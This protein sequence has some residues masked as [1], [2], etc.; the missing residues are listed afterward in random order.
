MARLLGA[1]YVEGEQAAEARVAH[2]GD[3]RMALQ[4]PGEL[5]RR[6]GLPAHPELERL[7]PAQE[8]GA[9]IR[10][11]HDAEPRPQLV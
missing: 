2:L 11:R 1:R 7:Q 8:Q 9:G 4:A 6:L 10:R 3:G 5:G